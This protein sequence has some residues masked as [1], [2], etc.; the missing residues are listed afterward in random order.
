M[1]FGIVAVLE[2]TMRDGNKV[3]QKANTRDVFFIVLEV[4]MRDGNTILT[5]HSF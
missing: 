1:L 3:E 5:N 4:T 2:V